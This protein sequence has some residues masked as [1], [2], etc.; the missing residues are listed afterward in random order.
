[1]CVWGGGAY[2]LSQDG[3]KMEERKNRRQRESKRKHEGGWERQTR[4]NE[5]A[6]GRFNSEGSL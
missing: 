3:E 5:H 1:M 6:I 4:E 2:V